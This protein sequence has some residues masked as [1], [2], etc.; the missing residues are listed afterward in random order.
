MACVLER[1]CVM[2]RKGNS[3]EGVTPILDSPGIS[4]AAIIV[5][6]EKIWDA[7]ANDDGRGKFKNILLHSLIKSDVTGESLERDFLESAV[8]KNGM[9]NNLEL[10]VICIACAYALQRIKA[11][12]T[13]NMQQD[14]WRYTGKA[15][16]W[17]GVVEHEM[18][19]RLFRKSNG[20]TSGIELPTIKQVMSEL[21]KKG[22]DIRHK[23]NR[24]SREEVLRYY[25]EHINE[26]RSKNQAAEAIAGKIVPFPFETMRGWLKER[27]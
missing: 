23:E 14:G 11:N 7:I 2:D 9:I 19:Y 5:N 26:Y 10:K 18:N 13:L 8:N 15:A 4:C 6:T 12:N 27:K 24:A 17:L 16:Y 3:F 22:L 25:K 1:V 20:T 21:S